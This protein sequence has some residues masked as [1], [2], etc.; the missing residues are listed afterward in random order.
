MD[1]K[2]YMIEHQWEED[3]I[4]KAEDVLRCTYTNYFKPEAAVDRDGDIQMMV[5]AL[6]ILSHRSALRLVAQGGSEDE[7]GAMAARA[8]AIKAK[9]K[10]DRDHIKEFINGNP[11]LCGNGPTTTP[12]A[13]WIKQRKDHPMGEM[14]IWIHSIPGTLLSR[15]LSETF[16]KTRENIDFF[17]NCSFISGL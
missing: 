15:V 10:G 7:G 5:G 4:A 14:G 8:C 6:F 16:A 1:R 2:S 17:C 12:L 13:W 11:E 3:W 9:R